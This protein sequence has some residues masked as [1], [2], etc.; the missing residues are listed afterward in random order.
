M[1]PFKGFWGTVEQGH[2]FLGN[3]GIKIRKAILGNIGNKVFDF[4][5]RGQKPFFSGYKGTGNK[6]TPQSVGLNNNFFFVKN[7]FMNHPRDCKL[8]QS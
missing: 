2:L 5:S 3:K 1:R 4:G 8:K 7:C 6:P